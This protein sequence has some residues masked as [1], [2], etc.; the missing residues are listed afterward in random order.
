MDV[1]V[2][3]ANITLPTPDGTNVSLYSLRGKYILLD[4][5]A[6]WCAPC[7]GENPNVVAA[8][9]KYK[10]RNFTIYSVSLDSK[11][12]AWEKAIQDDGLAWTQVSDLKGW[13]S[14][15]VVQYAVQSIPSNFLLSPTGEIIARDLR[16]ADL[17]Q[18][19]SNVLK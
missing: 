8:Y 7:R 14:S 17:D 10:N 18:T 3:A 9:Q 2:M 15:A 16:G 1:G 4:F 5:W 19:L 11:K 13:Q 6:S 12:E